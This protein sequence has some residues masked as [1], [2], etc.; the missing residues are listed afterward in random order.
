MVW[1]WWFQVL[2]I[3]HI[4]EYDVYSQYLRYCDIT[5][6]IVI[7]S[8]CA[9]HTLFPIIFYISLHHIVGNLETSRYTSAFSSWHSRPSVLLFLHITSCNTVDNNYY[10]LC[11]DWPV[12]WCSLQFWF[13][14]C[15]EGGWL[16]F[17]NFVCNAIRQMFQAKETFGAIAG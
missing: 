17:L 3:A 10:N 9:C 13:T 1:F 6:D 15:R 5:Y 7:T 16:F 8:S 11:L 12:H 4:H 14:S 2:Y